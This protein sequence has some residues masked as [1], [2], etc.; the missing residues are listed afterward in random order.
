MTQLQ[1][2][3]KYASVELAYALLKQAYAY[4]ATKDAVAKTAIII[5]SFFIWFLLYFVS[6]V[7]PGLPIFHTK[8]VARKVINTIAIKTKNRLGGLAET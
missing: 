5:F 3:V 6:F 2:Q 4:V 1:E 8:R 7:F